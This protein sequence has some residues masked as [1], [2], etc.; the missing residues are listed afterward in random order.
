MTVPGDSTRLARRDFLKTAGAA[1]VGAGVG[2]FS[3]VAADGQEAGDLSA[4]ETLDALL[5]KNREHEQFSS[6]GKN[7]HVPMV[8]IALYRL[9]GS[10]RQLQRYADGFDL[11]PGFAPAD[12]ARREA[13]T[14]ET[15]R[16]S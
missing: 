14:R 8:L 1:A 10:P 12:S 2:T 7:N 11:S 6:P 4:K 13:P 3:S 16:S 15:W 9:G 5:K